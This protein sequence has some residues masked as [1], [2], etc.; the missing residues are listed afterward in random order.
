MD[1]PKE[2]NNDAKQYEQWEVSVSLVFNVPI[3]A[4][5]NN[6]PDNKQ[7]N[8]AIG[9][10]HTIADTIDAGFNGNVHIVLGEDYA[11]SSEET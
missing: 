3:S 11:K 4:Y 10:A 7:L 9:V 6:F 2:P 1:T 5:V 8:G